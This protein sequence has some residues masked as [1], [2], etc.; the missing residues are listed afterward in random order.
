MNKENNVRLKLELL[1]A[2]IDELGQ[3]FVTYKA[4]SMKELLENTLKHIKYKEQG[5]EEL[6]TANL[7]LG[8]ELYEKLQ[9]YMRLVDAIEK[10]CKHHYQNLEPF[11]RWFFDEILEIINENKE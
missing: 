4:E 3:K 1:I 7:R 5:C 10:F 8:A 2:N 6:N 11:N 9:N